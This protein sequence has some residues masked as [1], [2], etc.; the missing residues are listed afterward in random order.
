MAEA[1][2][3]S[4][5]PPRI[6]S[7]D[8]RQ[9]FQRSQIRF[10]TENSGRMT[11]DFDVQTLTRKCYLLRLYIPEGFPHSSPILAIVA[12]S[13]LEQ[14]NGAALPSNSPEFHTLCSTFEGFPVISLAYPTLNTNANIY[15]RQIFLKGVLWLN[16][17]EEHLLTGVNPARYLQEY[18]QAENESASKSVQFW[19]HTQIG[20]L[21]KEKTKLDGFFGEDCVTWSSDRRSV[22]VKVTPLQHETEYV[23]RVHLHHDYPNS[24]PTLAI[25]QPSVLLQVNGEPLPLNSQEFHTI[26]RKDGHVLISHFLA[27]EWMDNYDIVSVMRKGQVWVNAYEQYI[28]QRDKSFG[29]CLREFNQCTESNGH[30]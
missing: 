9:Y 1:P 11:V 12:P 26:A 18:R 4:R 20:R 27:S 28:L 19:S 21:A 13:R 15:V 22:D 16:A 6:S 17:Y 10:N 14:R 8:L 3:I 23:L 29:D 30:C 2:E 25:I 7:E 5:R 24:C